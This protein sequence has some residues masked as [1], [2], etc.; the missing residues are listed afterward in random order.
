MC[1]IYCHKIHNVYLFDK[2]APIFAADLTQVGRLVAFHLVINPQT[3]IY[4]KW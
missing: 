1:N 3:V 4:K 2:S